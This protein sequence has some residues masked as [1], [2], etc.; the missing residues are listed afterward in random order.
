MDNEIFLKKPINTDMIEIT[1]FRYLQDLSSQII[2][3]P[4][5]NCFNDWYDGEEHPF[6]EK[7][8]DPGTKIVFKQ[9]TTTGI[10]G[11]PVAFKDEQYKK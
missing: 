4:P 11:E 5:L 8:N 3:C 2:I 1:M 7:S 9:N 10:E 6:V